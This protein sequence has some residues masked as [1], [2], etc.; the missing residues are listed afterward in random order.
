MLKVALLFVLAFGFVACNEDDIAELIKG[1]PIALPTGFYQSSCV[2]DGTD[3]YD[4]VFEI[5]SQTEIELN[6]TTYAGV[7]DCSNA[8]TNTG[9]QPITIELSD[10]SYANSVAFIYVAGEDS[11][12]A[13]HISD[14]VIYM[15]E[16]KEGVTADNAA[17]SFSDFIA[18]PTENRE[19]VL[20]SF[21][22]GPA[23]AR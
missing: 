9:A 12:T 17:S 5:V 11:T 15:S 8:G 13:Y 23:F 7:T 20:T 21:E 19:R 2:V 6:E 18:N 16:G 3:S 4:Q 10:F 22:P 1:D 14:G